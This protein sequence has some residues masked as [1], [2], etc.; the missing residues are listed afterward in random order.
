MLNPGQAHLGEDTAHLR[1]GGH[2][3]VPTDALKDPVAAQ[4]GH[5]GQEQFTACGDDDVG[6]ARFV[7]LNR[8]RFHGARMPFFVQEDGTV[9]RHCGFPVNVAGSVPDRILSAC[10]TRALRASSLVPQRP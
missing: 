7:G 4:N 10:S 8:G 2:G 6:D 5:V 1:A 3:L 9:L